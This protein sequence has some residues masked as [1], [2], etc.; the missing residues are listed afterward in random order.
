MG[1]K[2]L[3]E[4]FGGEG[5]GHIYGGGGGGGPKENVG[6][7]LPAAVVPVPTSAEPITEIAEIIGVG[8][9]ERVFF[10][11]FGRISIKLSFYLLHASTPYRI[12]TTGH[13]QPIASK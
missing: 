4:A 13:N 8:F 6:E 9:S 11:L 12:N 2:L 3:E 10:G 5:E 1:K 7:I